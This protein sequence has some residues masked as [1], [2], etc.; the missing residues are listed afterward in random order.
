VKVIQKIL[1]EYNVDPSRIYSVSLAGGSPAMWNT[2]MSNPGLFAAQISTSYDPYHAYRSAKSGEENLAILLKA[3]P[4][5]FFAGLDD[6]TGTGILGAADTRR[7]GE[8]LRDIAAVMNKKGFNI[9][10]AYGKEGEWMWNGLLRGDKANK[11]ADDQLAR[12]K[13]RNAS[14][15]VTLFMPTTILETPHWSWDA[16]YSN[17]AVRNWLFQQVNR[18]PYVPAK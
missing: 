3:L 8:R 6:P 1:S 15:L 2:I 10:I 9:D 11:L 16:T 4:G 17:A 12:A 14:H 7:K 18:A 5:W 13:V